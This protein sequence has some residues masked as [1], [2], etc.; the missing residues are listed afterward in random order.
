MGSASN[1]SKPLF[2][3]RNSKPLQTGH[4]R[5]GPNIVFLISLGVEIMRTIANKLWQCEKKM[6][7]F[8]VQ[9]RMRFH[10]PPANLQ[11][12]NV[13]RMTM[14]AFMASQIPKMPQPTKGPVKK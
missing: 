11:K 13:P 1:R 4:D 6:N 5:G 14:S 9:T 7:G 3:G 12:S 2:E 8:V 10:L